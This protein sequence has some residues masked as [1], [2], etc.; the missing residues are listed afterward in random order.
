MLEVSRYTIRTKLHEGA[1]RVIYRGTR[2][3]DGAPVVIKLLKEE[4]T[5][6]QA[7][8]RLRHEFTI[9]RSIDSPGVIKAY[10]L[11]PFGHGVALILEDTG[12]APLSDHLRGRPLALRQA[13]HVARSIARILA[14]L[15]AQGVIHKDLKPLNIVADSNLESV[16]LIDFGIATRLSQETQTARRPDTLEGTLAY[17]SPEQTGRMN[18]VVDYR[19]DFYSLGVTL[20]EML[21]GAL[22]FDSTDIVELVHSHIARSPAPPHDRHPEVPEAVSAIVMKLLAKAAEDRYQQALGLLTDLDRCITALDES[23]RVEPFTLGERDLNERLQIPQKLYGR[24]AEEEALLA[25]LERAAEGRSQLVLVTGAAGV[26]KSAL[27]QE[28]HKAI[29]RRGGRFVTGKFDQLHREVPFATFIHAFRELISHLLGEPPAKLAEWKATLLGVLGTNGQL[30]IDLIPELALVIG[31]QPPTLALGPSESQNRLSMVMQNFVRVFCTPSNPLVLFIDDLQWADAASLWLLRLLLSE[32][33]SG[34]LLI[35]GAYRDGEVDESHPLRGALEELRKGGLEPLDIHLGLLDFPS[36]CRLLEETFKESDRGRIGPLAN[37]VTAKTQGNPFFLSQ[38]LIELYNLKLVRLDRSTGRWVW[39]EAEVAAAPV[40]D[41]VVDFMA[42]RIQALDPST[43][44]VLSLAACTGHQFVL[45]SLAAVAELSPA[46]TAVALWPALR[47]RLLVPV[48]GD[49]RLLPEA[50]AG[51]DPAPELA[52]G[53]DASY[54]F[55]HDRVQ[56]AAY[57]LIPVDQ[58]E[59]VHLRIGRC[60]RS[61][62][63]DEPKAELLFEVVRHLNIGAALISDRKERVDLA[64]QDLSAGRGAKTAA[65]FAAAAG[66]YS[67]GIVALGERSWDDVYD[68]SS[69]LHRERAE[70]EYMAGHLEQAEEHIEALLM[71]L[72]S[73]GERA[74]IFGLRTTLYLSVGRFA[75]ALEAGCQGL[76]LIGVDVPRTKDAANAAFAEVSVAIERSL[77]DRTIESLVD[78]PLVADPDIETALR[79]L[80]NLKIPA[81]FGQPALYPFIVAKAVYLSIAHGN[82]QTSADGYATYGFFLTG[83]TGRYAESV[84]F[85]KLALALVDKFDMRS[86]AHIVYYICSYFMPYS[87]PL[88][89]ALTYLDHA[90]QTG[91]ECGDLFYGSAAFDEHAN[92]QFRLGE[93]LEEVREEAE[94]SEVIVRRYRIA[95]RIELV[96]VLQGVVACLQ[97][98]TSSPSSFSDDPSHDEAWLAR[99]ISGAFDMSRHYFCLTKVQVLA[100]HGD[101]RGA[102]AMIE[103]AEASSGGAFAQHW[104]TE[105]PFHAGIALAA[106]HATA[107]P[108]E[109]P[110]LLKELARHQAKLATFADACPENA[111]HQQMLVA[112]EVARIEGRPSEAIDAYEQAIKLAREHGFP[113]HEALANELYGKFFLE[114]GQLRVARIYLAEAYHGYARWGATVKVAQLAKQVPFLVSTPA[115]ELPWTAFES[116]SSSTHGTTTALLLDVTAALRAAQAIASEIILEKVVYRVMR[117]VLANAGAE[118][119]FLILNHQGELRVDA[120]L[121]VSPD[122]VQVGLN[123][124]LDSRED[125]A[126][127]V[128]RLVA[129][130]MDPVVLRN[131]RSDLRFAGDPYVAA[132][133]P[134]SL[135]CI[136]LAHQG[137]LRGVLYLENNVTEGAFTEERVELLAMLCTQAAI[138]VENALLYIHV[139]EVSAK[140][141]EANQDLEAEIAERTEELRAAN[142]HLQRRTEELRQTNE[143]LEH[144]LHE[145]E[146]SERSRAALQ[147]EVIQ[148]QRSLLEEL[149]TPLI[150]MNHEI[151]V[152]PLIGTVDRRRADQ[153]LDTVLE[154]VARQKARSVIVDITGL[155]QVD[156]QVAE[157]LVRMT[158][159]LRLLGAEA[160]ITG[161]RPEVARTLVEIGADLTMVVTR[162]TLQAGIAH[163]TR[164]TGRQGL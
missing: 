71:R 44:R 102:V 22:P 78:A 114:R 117:I 65:A 82:G 147:D 145:R 113:H 91:L 57:S 156:G 72:R 47:E 21:T 150:P 119:G 94:R 100:L 128:V 105:L 43:Q 83:A 2:D 98:R 58:R 54:R 51:D 15:H 90:R 157:T 92:V 11:E 56:Q 24:E 155:R 17:I 60:L 52:A 140:L 132:A 136:A 101:A 38:F 148:M 29:A 88:R 9:L 36:V 30:L 106:L 76:A 97:G 107:S 116:T 67:A 18:R 104:T 25:A 149:S 63:P 163:A 32:P 118:R 152:L 42:A 137:R 85:G 55:L 16:E 146:E 111:R 53:L 133:E 127:S 68:L 154:G 80:T 139:Q 61:A 151:L 130:T 110:G 66:F 49:Y 4:H 33:G 135:L 48:G 93:P 143:R 75:E 1:E 112:A 121:R 5:R 77:A 69:T 164:S 10:A 23:G 95:I 103:P 109:R 6:P 81:Y 84:R 46:R 158:S 39:D 122:A 86:I 115:A 59:E 141:Q 28:L 131:A 138:A 13:L 62:L 123:T 40:T 14:N 20:Y 27:V 162:G 126:Q 108:E 79:I 64:R 144:E 160:I 50:D 41:N 74:E 19:T 34:H 120:F 37:L 35:V 70:C 96:M 87:R 3:E 161:M 142:E 129:R 124:S 99:L 73:S 153:M 89:D 8:A 125:L 45:T 7:V 134:K 31:P 12:K 26:G 159:A